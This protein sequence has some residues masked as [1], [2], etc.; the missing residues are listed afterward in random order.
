[1]RKRGRRRNCRIPIKPS[2]ASSS[3]KLSYS[4]LDPNHSLIDEYVNLNDNISLAASLTTYCNGTIADGVS[5]LILL[6]NSNNPLQFSINDTERDNLTNGTLSCLDQSNV[7][8]L[9]SAAKVI[10]QNTNRQNI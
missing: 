5:K 6:I 10:P 2:S 1:M 8:N 4:I 9:F 7:D 3:H